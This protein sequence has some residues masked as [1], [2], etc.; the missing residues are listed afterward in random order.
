MKCV[1]IALALLCSAQALKMDRP[2]IS[3]KLMKIHKTWDKLDK[4]AGRPLRSKMTHKQRK[5]ASKERFMNSPIMSKGTQATA[6]EI[7]DTTADGVLDFYL[8]YNDGD[9]EM[10]AMYANSDEDAILCTGSYQNQ[11]D[12]GLNDAFC[13][14]IDSWNTDAPDIINQVMSE[15]LEDFVAGKV[16]TT[17]TATYKGKKRAPFDEEAVTYDISFAYFD[18]YLVIEYVDD[19]ISGYSFYCDEVIDGANADLVGNNGM[20]AA[21]DKDAEDLEDSIAASAAADIATKQISDGN[22]GTT[23]LGGDF[24]T[25]YD[26]TLK[27]DDPMKELFRKQFGNKVTAHKKRWKNYHNW[28]KGKFRRM[29]RSTGRVS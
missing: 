16:K 29:Q 9:L 13:A 14:E 6:A 5:A 20:D 21:F 24:I 27:Q 17:L 1:I 2:R 7:C 26:A 18:A 28:R 11:G 22:G 4:K 25:K 23:T 19:T 10:C 3:E 8:E 15:C 12:A